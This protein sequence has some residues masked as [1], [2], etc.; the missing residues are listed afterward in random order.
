MGR[1]KAKKIR[2]EKIHGMADGCFDEV[3]KFSTMTRATPLLFDE[4]DR[5]DPTLGLR[6]ASTRDRLKYAY[7]YFLEALASK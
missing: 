2:P 3:A 4:L 6:I 7:D 5:R 1:K